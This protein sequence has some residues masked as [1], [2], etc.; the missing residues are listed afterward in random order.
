MPFIPAPMQPR[1]PLDS[2][3]SKVEK[4]MSRAEVESIL[5]DYQP[6]EQH[7]SDR[8]TLLVYRRD[9]SSPRFDAD[10]ALV[11]FENGRV[12]SKQFLPA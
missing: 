4:G 9:P 10:G 5:K 6:I 12:V 8:V 11:R 1:I 3:V 2:A 7:L